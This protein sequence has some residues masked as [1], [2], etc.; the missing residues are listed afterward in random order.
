MKF[1]ACILSLILAAGSLNAQV[2]DKTEEKAKRKTNQRVDKKIDNSI[3]EGLDAIEGLF[4]KKKK[5]K[6]KDNSDEG[7]AK[8]R[9]P[10]SEDPE[11]SSFMNMMGSKTIDKTYDFNQ[12]VSI[13]TQV[14]DKKGNSEDSYN[15]TM[16]L[17]SEHPH[18]GMNMEKGMEGAESLE[19]MIFDFDDKQMLMMMNTQGQKMGFS[20]S[21]ENLEEDESA[22][23]V[24][25]MK[26]TKTG[27]SKTISGYSCDEYLIEGEDLKDGESQTAWITQDAEV[28]W[29]ESWSEAMSANKKAEMNQK[30]PENYPDGAVIQ[31]EYEEKSGKRYVMTVTNIDTDHNKSVSTSGYK[32]MTMPEGK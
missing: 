16:Y 31:T 18:I 13:E 19:M 22:Q 25:E 28:N 21:T 11:M 27:N 32:F 29:I 17:S 20:M 8:E 12:R 5:K 26:I 3:D 23:D 4:K 2:V 6:N 10:K 30:L 24:S 15:S 7:E 14:I 1:F 9:S